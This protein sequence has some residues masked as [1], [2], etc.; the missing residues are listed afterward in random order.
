M[1]RAAAGM[2]LLSAALLAGCR[3]GPKYVVP[4]APVPP[5]YKELGPDAFKETAEWQHAHPEDA[6]PRGTWWTI[7]TAT[8]R[9]C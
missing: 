7:R 8:T 2:A 5:A 1:K 6:I 3:V 4:T 9:S